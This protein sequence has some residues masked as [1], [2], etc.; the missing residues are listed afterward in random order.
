MRNLGSKVKK[1]LFRE[2]TKLR[3]S[4]I[5]RSPTNFGVVGLRI[6]KYLYSI[7]GDASVWERVAYE[8]LKL[9]LDFRFANPLQSLDFL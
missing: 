6:Q 4:I 2:I 1:S 5:K 9:L 3:G 7:Y 8:D